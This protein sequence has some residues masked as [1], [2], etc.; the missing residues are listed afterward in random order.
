MNYFTILTNYFVAK[1]PTP[2]PPGNP[3]DEIAEAIRQSQ[4]DYEKAE[5]LKK[6]EEEELLKAINESLKSHQSAP[7][8]NDDSFRLQLEDTSE[9]SSTPNLENSGLVSKL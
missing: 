1:I 3:D 5:I 4:E 7:K 8:P 2:E 6:K 9:N